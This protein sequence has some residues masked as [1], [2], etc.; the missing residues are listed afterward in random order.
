M[1]AVDVLRRI[2]DALVDQLMH[3]RH[4]ASLRAALGCRT[5]C[6]TFGNHASLRALAYLFAPPRTFVAALRLRDRFYAQRARGRLHEE[7]FFVARYTMYR[8]RFARRVDASTLVPVYWALVGHV[9]EAFMQVHRTDR[10]AFIDFV[11]RACSSLLIYLRS[12]TDRRALGVCY[13][14]SELRAVLRALSARA[15]GGVPDGGGGSGGGASS[16]S[17]S[18]G[19]ADDDNG[20]VRTGSLL[21]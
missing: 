4:A 11:T 13:R 9:G 19:A 3:E 1:F 6:T 21:F 8:T 18:S 12:R 14:P 2:L 5:V 16:S 20:A 15:A 17:S 10:E 7:A